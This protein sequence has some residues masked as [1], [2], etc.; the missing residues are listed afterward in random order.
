[1]DAPKDNEPEYV[2]IHDIR[3][4]QD[5]MVCMLAVNEPLGLGLKLEYHAGNLPKFMQWKSTASG[6]Y[7]IGLEP[8]NSSVYGRPYDEE[9]GTVHR[10]APFAHEKNVL[11]FT[12]LDSPEE[13]HSAVRE[14][15][16]RN[17]ETMID[18]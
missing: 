3:P 8:A 4:D 10:L 2:F 15:Q 5:G 14:F 11:H 17:P 6:D 18:Q 13:I 1:M 9:H 7:V 12:V 16:N